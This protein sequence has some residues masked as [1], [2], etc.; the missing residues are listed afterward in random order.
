MI[1]IM[2]VKRQYDSLDHSLD[3]RILELL[4]SGKYIMGENVREFEREFAHYLNANYCISVGNGTDALEIAL[5]ALGISEGDEVIIPA[6][7]FFATAESVSVVGAKPVFVD[8]D[9]STYLIDTNQII[10]KITNKTKAIIPVH[11]YGQCCDMDK[12][13]DIAKKYNIKVVEDC[14]QAAGA[15]Y[16]GKKAGTIGDIGCYSFF[17]TKNLGACGDGG[18]IITNNTSLMI[19]CS[20]LRTHGSGVNG[21]LAAY[22]LIEKEEIGKEFGGMLPKYFNYI[23]GRNSRLDEIQALI[24]REKLKK[25][26]GWNKKRNYIASEYRNKI[27]NRLIRHPYTAEKCTH[28]FYVYQ[29]KTEKRDNLIAFLKENKISSGCYFPVPMHLQEVY[30]S[31]GYKKGDFPVAETIADTLLAIPIYP[32]LTDIEISHIIETVNSYNVR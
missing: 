9:E 11:L 14:A 21:Y 28:V 10:S 6:M 7:T 26:D 8:C 30:K 18:A 17:P 31:L 3:K 20:A 13:M 4:H 5:K 25:L 12:I 16:K 22:N 27:T 2:N 1:D 24:L 15:T 32:E 19:A 29:I 23:I